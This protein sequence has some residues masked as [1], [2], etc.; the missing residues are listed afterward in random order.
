M[1]KSKRQQA[2]E[3]DSHKSL[4]VGLASERS[5][6]LESC[7]RINDVVLPQSDF[8]DD[9]AIP[10]KNTDA[11][12]QNGERF[13]RALGTLSLEANQKILVSKVCGGDN[14]K[15]RDVRKDL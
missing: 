14:A 12:R 6:P 9:V 2:K 3:C 10:N 5:I 1:Q 11:A 13:A 8:V 4:S 15:V 7:A